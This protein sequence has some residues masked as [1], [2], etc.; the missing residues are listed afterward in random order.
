MRVSARVRNHPLHPPLTDLPAALLPLS[1]LWY[2]VALWR[3]GDF[4]WQAAFWTLVA[5]LVAAVPT[6]AAG[7]L[8]YLNKVER[9]SIAFRTATNHMLVMLTAVSLFAGSALAQGGPDAMSGGQAALV[10]GLA[11]AGALGLG[12]G[13]W[14]GGELVFRD[15]VGV[16]TRADERVVPIPVTTVPDEPHLRVTS[17]NSHQRH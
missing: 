4:W 6:A 5:G 17:G 10:I 16:A 12:I 11:A 9:G 2:L 8:D 1:L 13:G 15:G 3:G 14:L 7:F